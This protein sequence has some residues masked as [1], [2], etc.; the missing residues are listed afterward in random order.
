MI[1]RQIKAGPMQ[2]FVYIIGDEKTKEAAIVDAGWDIKS[3]ILIAEKEGLKISKIILTHSHFDHIQLA[4]ELAV[5]TNACI[6]VHES[7]F[8]EVSNSIRK[9]NPKITKVGDGDKIL[10]GK[11]E[12]KVMHTPG[13]TKGS[14]CILAEDKLVTG[15]TLF[16]NAVGRTDL[17][18][19]DYKKLMESLG[20][21]KKLNDSIQV[22]P[23][24]DYGKTAYSTIGYEKKN[25][26]FMKDA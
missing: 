13:H 8:N 16:V 17:S 24:H 23:G 3:V 20:M 14:I 19:G 7:D 2:N 12:L 11:I 18:G 26:P 9:S 4:G 5:K 6:Y 21:L 15:D 1:F 22:Y 10:V 25:N